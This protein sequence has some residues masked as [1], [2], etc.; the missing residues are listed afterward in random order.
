MGELPDEASLPSY[1]ELPVASEGGRSR[2]GVFGPD[3]KAS[4]HPEVILEATYGWYRAAD[5]LEEYF[6]S[7]VHHLN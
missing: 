1:D 2:W 7:G 3:D 4:E 6:D 5:V